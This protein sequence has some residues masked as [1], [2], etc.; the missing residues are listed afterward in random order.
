ML[1]WYTKLDAISRQVYVSFDGADSLVIQADIATYHSYYK[2][3][4]WELLG[5]ATPLPIITEEATPI[6]KQATLL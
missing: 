1:K 2:A 5:R 3:L 6:N 4:G